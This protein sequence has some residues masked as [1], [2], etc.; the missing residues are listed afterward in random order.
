M[1][2]TGWVLSLWPTFI[3]GMSSIWKLSHNAWYVKEFTRIGWPES[4][5]PLL[6]CLQLG[7]LILFLIPRTSILGAILLT[8]YLG[9]AIASYVRIGEFYPPLVPLSTAVVAWAGAFGREKRLRAL[10][11]FHL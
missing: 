8:G 7:A 10:I 1:Y 11:P 5:L 6:A 9:G 3:V 2:W 4:A